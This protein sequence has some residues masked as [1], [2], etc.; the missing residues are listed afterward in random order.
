MK[1]IPEHFSEWNKNFIEFEKWTVKE[2]ISKVEACIRFT[3]SFKEIK[4]I[5]L[6]VNNLGQ[7]KENL[8]FL[9]KK[10]LIVPKSLNI[11]SGLILNPRKWK[12]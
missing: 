4:K 11:N 8:N 5:I 12:L 10:K 6:G 2:K 1:K 9:K 7:L 3:N